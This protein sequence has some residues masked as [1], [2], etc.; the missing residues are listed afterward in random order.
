W[1]NI[2][3]GFI[4]TAVQILSLLT[5]TSTIYYIFFS[6]IEISCTAFI[7]WYA[8]VWRGAEKPVAVNQI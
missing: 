8:W 5:G 6:A 3:A 1:A 2:I 7:V 4:M